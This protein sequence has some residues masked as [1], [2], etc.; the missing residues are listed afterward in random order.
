MKTLLL[1]AAFLIKSLVLL[2]QVQ[3]YTATVYDSTKS[4]G[5]YFLVPARIT[6]PNAGIHAQMILDRYGDLV[7][8]NPLGNIINTTDFKVQPNGMITYCMNSKFNIRRSA[9]TVSDAVACKD[10]AS[11]DSHK[12]QCDANGNYLSLASKKGMIGLPAYLWFKPPG[13][14]GRT[15]AEVK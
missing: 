11:A 6:N 2:S 14:Q 3:P 4:T 5:Y 1:T 7:Y 15:V 9:C 12:L 13:T 8:Y 10:G